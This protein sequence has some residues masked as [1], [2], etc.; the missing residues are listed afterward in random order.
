M[1]LTAFFEN[2]VNV[3]VIENAFMENSFPDYDFLTEEMIIAGNEIESNMTL[4]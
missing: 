4:S 3:A 2:H 1:I